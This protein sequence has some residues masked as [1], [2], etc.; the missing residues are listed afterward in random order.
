MCESCHMVILQQP[1]APIN[2]GAPP[3]PLAISCYTKSQVED[4]MLAM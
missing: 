3:F 2:R 4:G 1:L